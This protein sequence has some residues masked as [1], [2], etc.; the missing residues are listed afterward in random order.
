MEWFKTPADFSLL[1]NIGAGWT[2]VP[3]P[4]NS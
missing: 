3:L 1:L 2:P 4:N